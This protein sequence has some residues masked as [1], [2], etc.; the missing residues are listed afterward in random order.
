MVVLKIFRQN[1]KKIRQEIKI[2][3]ININYLQ[4]QLRKKLFTKLIG[5]MILLKS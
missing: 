1:I 4:I 3:I 5:I 2:N